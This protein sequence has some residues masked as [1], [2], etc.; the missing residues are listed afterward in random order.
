M[1]QVCPHP[2]TT[3]MHSASSLDCVGLLPFIVVIG[4]IH[5]LKVQKLTAGCSSQKSVDTQN[6]K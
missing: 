5:H 2:S 3:Q 4:I 1:K 6:T